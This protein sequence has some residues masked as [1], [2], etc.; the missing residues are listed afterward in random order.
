MKTIKCRIYPTKKQQTIFNQTLNECRWLYNYVL[1]WHN[2]NYKKNKKYVGYHST[3][4]LIPILKQNRDTLHNVHAQVLQNV[5]MR[6]DKTYQ[7]FF[8]RI[9]NKEN[10]GFPRFKSKNR[11]Q[12]FTYPQTGHCGPKLNI[13]NSKIYLPKIGN[14]NIKLHRIPENIK[15]VT[16]SKSSTEKWFIC[17]DCDMVGILLPNNTQQ[18]GIDVGL[19][20]FA[21]FNNSVKIENPRFFKI[22]EKK[23]KK[24][25]Q[26]LS[27][28]EKYSQQWKKSKKVLAHIHKQIQNKRSN[29]THQLSRNI[30]NNYG[31]IAIEDLSINCMIKKKKYLAKSIN[32]V[33]WNSFAKQLMYKA[34]EAG[35]QLVKVNP[36]YTS[37]DCSQCGYRVEKKLSD[38]MH[39]CPNCE[40]LLD[41]DINAARNILRLGLQSLGVNP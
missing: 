40:L 9:K 14:I 8:S 18:I 11:Y 22:S 20:S 15:R 28:Q 36:A 37:Q 17:F 32:D 5:I 27:K 26:K 30:I 6:V 39:H 41:R 24:T 23:I 2:N 35:R 16:I 4:K 12:S 34:V 7:N 25:C 10:P 13:N 3:T 31:I 21:T 38:R 19:E 1:E 33:A 29:F